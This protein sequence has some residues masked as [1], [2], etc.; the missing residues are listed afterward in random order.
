MPCKHHNCV[1][2][3]SCDECTLEQRLAFAK[4]QASL[5]PQLEAELESLQPSRLALKALKAIEYFHYVH[6]G[7][8]CHW[9]ANPRNIGHAHDCLRQRAIAALEA[10]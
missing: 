8:F 1:R 3:A 6:A 7:D 10:K 2:P 5:V 9:C 4:E